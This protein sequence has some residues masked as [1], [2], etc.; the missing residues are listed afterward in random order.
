M[1]FVIFRSKHLLR[2]S[3]S[4]TNCNQHQTAIPTAD[5][6]FKG[7]PMPFSGPPM[8][9]CLSCH[10]SIHRNAPVCPLC[11]AKS[12]SRSLKRKKIDEVSK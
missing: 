7:R 11:K 8:K 2:Y 3:D 1:Y 12:H 4:K 6:Q 9:S 5:S 10:Q